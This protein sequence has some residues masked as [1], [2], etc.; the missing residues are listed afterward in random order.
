[1]SRR[2]HSWLREGG[3]S[4]RAVLGSARAHWCILVEIVL[5]H[6]QLDGRGLVGFPAAL[7]SVSPELLVVL[8][9]IGAGEPGSLGQF[10]F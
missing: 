1:M 3:F 4:S 6:L 8:L 9:G 2:F 7:A 10:R 5:F